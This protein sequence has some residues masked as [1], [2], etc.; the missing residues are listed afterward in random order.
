MT[1]RIF[2]FFFYPSCSPASIRRVLK[3]AIRGKRRSGWDM[4]TRTHVPIKFKAPG[5]VTRNQ[6]QAEALG[7]SLDLAIPQPGAPGPVASPSGPQSPQL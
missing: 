2:F 6:R 5:S 1:L 4:N 7:S 3:K